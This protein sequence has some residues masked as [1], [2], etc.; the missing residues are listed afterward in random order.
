MGGPN[1]DMQY[2]AFLGGENKLPKLPALTLMDTGASH[3]F[4]ES[5]LVKQLQLQV[6]P[7]PVHDVLLADGTKSTLSGVCTF[8]ICGQGMQTS[9]CIRR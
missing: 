1:L 6:T 5:K 4:V 2:D 9:E 8:T 7:S 3:C